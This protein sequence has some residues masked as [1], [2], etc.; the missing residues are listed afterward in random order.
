MNYFVITNGGDGGDG[1]RRNAFCGTN[2][3]PGGFVLGYSSANGGDGGLIYGNG[4]IAMDGG[5][6]DGQP[7]T[8]TGN[9]AALISH[10]GIRFVLNP[11]LQTVQYL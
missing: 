1:T 6:A 4:G 8:N 3:G 11:H 7:D 9:G 2:G 10:T 5:I